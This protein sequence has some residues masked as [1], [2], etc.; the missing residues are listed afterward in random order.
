MVE[1]F[2]GALV[3]VAGWVTDCWIFLAPSMNPDVVNVVV[4]TAPSVVVKR[5]MTRSAFARRRMSVSA[6]VKN[7][8]R[9]S[10]E[11]VT[12]TSSAGSESKRIFTV[13]VPRLMPSVSIVKNSSIRAGLS[14]CGDADI[15]YARLGVY[16]IPS[17]IV[18][19]VPCVYRVNE[20]SSVIS[21]VLFIKFQFS[22]NAD[23]ET[24]KA[25]II[26]VSSVF[27]ARIIHQ[28]M[29]ENHGKKF[30]NFFFT[31]LFT[32]APRCDTIRAVF[33]SVGEFKMSNMRKT[34]RKAVLVL[35]ELE[36]IARLRRYAITNGLE[37]AKG[38]PNVAGALNEIASR[39]LRRLYPE[40]TSAE[41]RWCAAQQ[42]AN[43]AK[44]A[45]ACV[46]MKKGGSK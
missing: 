40:L 7:P 46:A 29:M 6:F 38:E 35:P 26:V 8:A 5:S 21:S 36:D 31:G 1:L 32:P 3:V 23:I 11:A 14:S 44:R 27:M 19:G 16:F 42:K 13:E 9:L 17:M 18:I 22:A 39:E 4:R 15:L 20:T 45:R 2:V 12:V 41:Y 43:E 33:N 30:F 37:N 25:E 24:I 10:V 34:T 28:P